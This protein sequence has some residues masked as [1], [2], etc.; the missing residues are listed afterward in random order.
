MKKIILSLL[1]FFLLLIGKFAY[2]NDDGWT[3]YQKNGQ[4]NAY[5]NAGLDFSNAS[6]LW[7]IKISD[8]LD[9]VIGDKN[10]IYLITDNAILSLDPANGHIL[11]SK[12]FMTASSINPPS[13]DDNAVY[14][15]VTD[16]DSSEYLYAFNRYN[17]KQIFKTKYI[18][19]GQAYLAPMSL[20]HNINTPCDH[21]KGICAYDSVDGKLLWSNAD[22]SWLQDWLPTVTD[23]YV[24]VPAYPLHVFDRKTGKVVFSLSNLLFPVWQGQDEIEDVSLVVGTLDDA[25]Y[26]YYNTSEYSEKSFLASV[27]LKKQALNWKIYE[28]YSGDPVIGNGVVYITSNGPQPT[29]IVARSEVDGKLLWTWYDWFYN[30]ADIT[31]LIL[32]NNILLIGS[33]TRTYAIS[34]DGKE[35]IWT[36][37]LGGTLTLIGNTLYIANSQ[38]R[39][40]AISVES[41]QSSAAKK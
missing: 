32:T 19:Q 4:R 29:K 16:N 22:F 36:Y 5:V 35:E 39:I 34:L 2:S 25:I 20:E 18:P 30:D 40:T 37:P 7:S 13:M 3:T 10:H 8:Y 21:M 12:T 6:Q 24:I 38:G 23:A 41:D 28:D 26:R 1:F 33:E 31:N 27:N 15:Q 14:L 9:Q 17:G 11:W